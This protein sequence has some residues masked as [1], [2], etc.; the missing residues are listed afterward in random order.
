MARA[1]L[2]LLNSGGDVSQEFEITRPNIVIGR[3]P[4]SNILISDTEISRI[5]AQ[6]V[7]TPHGFFIADMGSTNGT[8]LNGQAIKPKQ[9]IEL[10]SNDQVNLGQLDFLFQLVSDSVPIANHQYLP[11]T[12]SLSGTEI[13]YG[14]SAYQDQPPARPLSRQAKSRAETVT[15]REI[16]FSIP[17][18]P[19]TAQS[20]H[21]QNTINNFSNPT[22]QADQN[23]QRASQLA[24]QR[25]YSQQASQQTHPSHPY[26]MPLPGGTQNA[27]PQN[28]TQNK[29]QNRQT[30]IDE[31]QTNLRENQ[32]QSS[33][34]SSPS[35]KNSAYTITNLPKHDL[36]DPVP[37]LSQQE[38]N[39]LAQEIFADNTKNQDKKEKKPTIS[40]AGW[41]TTNVFD[42]KN[43]QKDNEKQS[44]ILDGIFQQAQVSENKQTQ[45][46]AQKKSIHSLLNDFNEEDLIETVL[47]QNSKFS[48]SL[49]IVPVSKVS[50][51]K[52]NQE[53]QENDIEFEEDELFDPADLTKQSIKYKIESSSYYYPETESNRS[54]HFAP[55][56]YSYDNNSAANKSRDPFQDLNFK[57]ND[58]LFAKFNVNPF[59]KTNSAAASQSSISN[60]VNQEASKSIQKKDFGAFMKKHGIP[61]SIGLIAVIALGMFLI[62]NTAAFG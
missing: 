21:S 17:F 58:S 47:G 8:F 48:S 54:N 40:W 37:N 57:D 26:I 42:K 35:Q 5:H 32:T 1:R 45:N 60:L 53:I 19:S 11:Q 39:A 56:Q 50:T 43:S 12:Q 51:S 33:N 4:Q 23:S 24:F 14:K 18:M 10:K 41:G 20:T 38:M 52:S 36:A 30:S 9:M 13:G 16:D 49:E 7:N 31:Q 28:N 55:E 29:T 22:K 3:S 27:T 2:L 15:S 6:I 34:Q 44:E 59:K 25:I 62:R 46:N 61:L